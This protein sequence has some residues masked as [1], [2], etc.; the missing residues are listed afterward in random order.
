MP[1]SERE[2][3]IRDAIEQE[4]DDWITEEFGVGETDAQWDREV[5][6][7]KHRFPKKSATLHR[8]NLKDNA[9]AGAKTRGHF[10][11]AGRWMFA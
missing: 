7:W 2:R 1:L 9:P 3:D 5:R 10:G 11:R 6:A 4:M 8:L